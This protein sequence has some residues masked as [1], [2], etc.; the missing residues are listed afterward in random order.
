M[1][2]SSSTLISVEQ[3]LNSRFEGFEP[4]YAHGEIV[5]RSMPTVIHSWLQSVLVMRMAI[6][7]F[8]LVAVRLRVAP[9][10]FRIPDIALF[11]GAL[12]A[13]AVPTKPP[14]VV[15]EIV[16]PDDRH[17][18]LLRKLAE[19]R[20]F[21]VRHIWVVEPELRQMH[22]YDGLSLVAVSDFSLPDLSFQIT[23]AELFSGI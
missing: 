13:E 11:T 2:S 7:G 20:D 3:Y 12:P 17:T 5:E 22:V 23:L 10:V 9:D 16:S 6:A 21:G 19:Y 18:D 8:P 1:A 15:V 4:E 14:L